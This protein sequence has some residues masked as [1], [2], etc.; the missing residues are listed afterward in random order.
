MASIKSVIYVSTAV[1]SLENSDLDDINRQ[2]QA[3][4]PGLNLTGVLAYNGTNFMQLLEGP[5]ENLFQCL[6]TISEDPRHQGMIIINQRDLTAR[7]FDGWAMMY[8]R[9]K[10]DGGQPGDELEDW[11]SANDVSNETR[12]IFGSFKTLGLA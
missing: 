1:P 9:Y 7:E 3:N 5:A 11:L 4:N 2:S 6:G 12:T 10:S 8:S